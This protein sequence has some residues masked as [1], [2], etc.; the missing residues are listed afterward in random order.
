VL[1]NN[2]LDIFKGSKPI[3]DSKK[4][5]VKPN[6]I[7]DIALD[8]APKR[9]NQFLYVGR[10]SQ[11]KGIDVLLDAFATLPYQLIIIGDGPLK[12]K[13]ENYCTLHRNITNL[14]FQPKPIIIKELIK[15]SALIFPSIWLETFGLTIIEAF[16][17]GTPV[18]ASNQG[19]ASLLIKDGFNGLH[20]KPENIKDLQR[21]VTKWVNLK[22]LFNNYFL[23]VRRFIGLHFE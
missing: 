21:I 10:L 18:I 12:S 17:T 19:S 15:T 20:F 3:I 16:A 1:T 11:E 7:E 4:I 8:A 6:F 9:L 14:G 2:S 23:Y 13:V 5:Q 22:I